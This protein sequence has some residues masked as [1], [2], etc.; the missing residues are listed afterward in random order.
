MMPR[1]SA[2]A[3]QI[4]GIRCES[5]RPEGRSRPMR[6]PK[7]RRASGLGKPNEKGPAFAGPFFIRPSFASL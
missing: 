6:A 7:V 4:V 5:R 1:C 3:D 2:I